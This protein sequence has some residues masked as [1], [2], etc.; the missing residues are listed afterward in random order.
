MRV[1]R[2]AAM[3][4]VALGAALGLAPTASAAACAGSGIAVT[5][6]G[7]AVRFSLTTG[8][9]SQTLFGQSTDLRG[10]AITPD[11]ATAYVVDHALA[12][13]AN[14]YVIDTATMTRTATLASGAAAPA[15]GTAIALSSDGSRLYIAYTDSAFTPAT[16]IRVIDTSSNTTLA[17]YASPSAN[18]ATG[19]VVS[20]DG[21]TLYI[22][23][24]AL[25]AVRAA[26]GTGAQT[27]S[28]AGTAL[29]LVQSSDGAT[30]YLLGDLSGTVYMQRGT[31]QATAL[32]APLGGRGLSLALAPD[33]ATLFAGVEGTG[34]SSLYAVNATSG[35]AAA[36]GAADATFG[37]LAL[38]ITPDGTTLLAGLANRVALLSPSGSALGTVAA[39]GAA[40]G[41]AACPAV[42]PSAPTAV[43]GDPGDTLVSVSW[44]APT[45]TGGAAITRYTATA[46][47]GGATCTTTGAT[48]CLFTGLKNNTAYTFTVTATNVAGTSAA[49]TAS[50]KATPHKDNR[51]RPLTIGPA[52]VTFTK[53]GVGVAVNVTATGP[54][55]IAAA[56][57]YKGDRYC[58]VSKRVT[59]AGTYRIK[60]VMAAA[61]RALARKR[62]TTY[63]LY[64]SFSPTNGPLASAKAAV[65]VPRRR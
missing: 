11:G 56:M 55:V 10:P 22:A 36:I 43:V 29:K 61:G 23:A 41:V 57:T 49:S 33:G 9:I 6:A 8:A 40:V 32:S 42:A 44:T 52:S 26:D 59:A 12:G 31:A 37:T 45:S 64:V 60:C 24:D 54:G 20:A 7:T 63:T 17:T 14:A 34:A 65:V 4:V 3:L 50:A 62:R 35:T 5:D 1:A 21:T 53:K 51:A 28:A 13:T 46:S 48:T 30:R 18:D 19:L 15:Q 58:S 27:L 47:P 25:Y 39:G 38:G 2:S 16:R